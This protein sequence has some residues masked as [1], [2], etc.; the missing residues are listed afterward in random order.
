MYCNFNDD[1]IQM[2]FVMAYLCVSESI[3]V[4]P[5]RVN[6]VIKAAWELKYLFGI[7]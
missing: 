2:L 5:V 3:E 4:L 1:L 6:I 7:C